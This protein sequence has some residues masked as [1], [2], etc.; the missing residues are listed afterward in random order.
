MRKS[1]FNAD[2]LDTAESRGFSLATAN[3][4]SFAWHLSTFFFYHFLKF[5]IIIIFVFN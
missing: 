1:Y 3:Y 5:S 4:I 2:L